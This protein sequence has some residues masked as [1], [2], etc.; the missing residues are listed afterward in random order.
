MQFCND[1]HSRLNSIYFAQKCLLSEITGSSM[2]S[3]EWLKYVPHRKKKRRET[4]LCFQTKVHNVSILYNLLRK[5]GKQQNQ[6]FLKDNIV[7]LII[8]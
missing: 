7:C 1:A 4:F 6:L 8:K 5:G 3:P 2:L